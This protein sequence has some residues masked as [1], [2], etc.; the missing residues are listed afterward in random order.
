[1]KSDQQTIKNM[2]NELNVLENKLFKA[3]NYSNGFESLLSINQKAGGVINENS[4]NK[5]NIIKCLN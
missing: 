1:M 2:V 3:V 5:T 4:Y